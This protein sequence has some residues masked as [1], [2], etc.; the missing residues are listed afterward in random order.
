MRNKNRSFIEKKTLKMMTYFKLCS[1]NSF[2]P[3]PPY[4]FFILQSLLKMHAAKALFK[5]AWVLSL[6]KCLQVIPRESISNVLQPCD[7]RGYPVR[8]TAPNRSRRRCRRNRPSM[9]FFPENA[10][11]AL[12][13]TCFSSHYYVC[14]VHTRS[15]R[16]ISHIIYFLEGDESKDKVSSLEVS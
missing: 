9:F 4:F 16:W 7:A 6:H 15:C 11:A 8:S 1:R 5:G 10:P 12:S 14:T 2:S 3:P 13:Y